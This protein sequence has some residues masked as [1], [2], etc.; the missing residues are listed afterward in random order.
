MCISAVRTA[1]S[2]V[3]VQEDVVHSPKKTGGWRSNELQ[4]SETSLRRLMK[5]DFGC[6]PYKVHIVQ[7]LFTHWF[8][9]METFLGH[10]GLQIWQLQIFFMGLPEGKGISNKTQELND[11][12]R[13]EIFSIRQET[14][15]SV[16]E[17]VVRR[18]QHCGSPWWSLTASDFQDIIC[19]QSPIC[20]L[21][22][23]PYFFCR[24]YFFLW[25]LPF[26]I[27]SWL[28]ADPVVWKRGRFIYLGGRR[29]Q[30]G[31]FLSW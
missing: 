17:C 3:A 14:L 26:E 21:S 12:I 27:Q 15:T 23:P 13:R 6:Y 22:F 16:M 29:K 28:L 31:T 11:S 25:V 10:P 2:I 20:A 1:A 19:E 9:D 7:K 24:S 5:K 18:I 30:Q 4:I 8:P